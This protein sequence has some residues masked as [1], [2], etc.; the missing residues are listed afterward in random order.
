VAISLFSYGIAGGTVD[1]QVRLA[2][3]AL[4]TAAIPVTVDEGTNE[5]PYYDATRFDGIE[6]TAA[7]TVDLFVTTGG[8]ETIQYLCAV[9]WCFVRMHA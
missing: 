7:D 1:V 6:I 2:G 8:A 4:L 3:A 9:V 5:T